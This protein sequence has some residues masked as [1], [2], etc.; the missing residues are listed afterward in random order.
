MLL[1][2]GGTW[3]RR[4]AE[5]FLAEGIPHCLVVEGGTKAW[6]AAGSPL[7]RGQGVISIERQVRI[8]AGTMV[9]LGVLLGSRVDPLWFFPERFCRGGTD[10]R[11]SNGLVWDGTSLGQDAVESELRRSRENSA[12]LA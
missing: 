7:V 2:A 9:L 10:F 12:L 11:G 8:G 1:C 6:E 3:A 4:A 5:K